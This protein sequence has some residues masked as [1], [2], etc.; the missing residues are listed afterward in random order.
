M[1]VREATIGFLFLILSVL[2]L[3]L[4][5]DFPG[6]HARGVDLPG[7]G[8]FPRFIAYLLICCAILQLIEAYREGRMTREKGEKLPTFCA[9]FLAFARSP[10]VGT[11]LITVV[12][13]IAYVP[14]L[15]CLGF[16]LTTLV[17][18]TV[19]MICFRVQLV[20]AIIYSAV[21]VIVMV[22]VFERMFHVPLPYGVFHL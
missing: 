10:G 17:F 2:V 7:P 11:M 20:P 19:M 14:C 1:N 9:T 4:T 6:F 8:F 22:I 5:R 3:I 16:Q 15:N 21:V 18:L 13:V 12:S